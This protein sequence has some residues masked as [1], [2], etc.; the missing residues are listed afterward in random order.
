LPSSRDLRGFIPHDAGL[1]Y[2]RRRACWDMANLTNEM[3]HLA[4]VKPY[5]TWVGTR[6][7]PQVRRMAP[8]WTTT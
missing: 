8:A 1:V 2:A 3:L 5:L 7:L 6:D 4:G